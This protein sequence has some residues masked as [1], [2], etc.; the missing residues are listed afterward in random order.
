MLVI[1]INIILFFALL[2]ALIAPAKVLPF[3]HTSNALRRAIAVAAYFVL[4]G[5]MA[6]LHGPVDVN[7][8][9]SPTEAADNKKWAEH[10]AADSTRLESDYFNPKNAKSTLELAARFEELAAI[11][12]QSDYEKEEITDSTVI[13]FA[14]RNTTAALEMIPAIMPAY[15]KQYAKLL[16]DELWRANIEVKLLNKGKTLELVGGIFASNNAIAEMQ[17]KIAGTLRT[18]GFTR[19][20]YRWVEYDQEYTYYDL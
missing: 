7:E 12:K 6:A 13:R 9:K 18:Y 19:V 1:L 10:A 8:I 15:R 11:I 5:C 4:W 20:Q 16:G 2:A 3:I 17:E 14:N